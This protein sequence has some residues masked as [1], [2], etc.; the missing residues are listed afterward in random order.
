MEVLQGMDSLK[1]IQTS[2]NEPM[3]AADFWK[4]YD[5]GVYKPQEGR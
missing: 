2:I 4:R 1:Q 5:L 3:S